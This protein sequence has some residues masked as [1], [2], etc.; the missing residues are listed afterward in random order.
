MTDAEMRQL[1]QIERQLVAE[2]PELR[3]L[4][5]DAAVAER[6]R[7]HRAWWW[8]GLATLVASLALLGCGLGLGIPGLAVSA[9][10]PPLAFGVVLLGG[11]AIHLRQPLWKRP[12]PPRPGSGRRR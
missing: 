11:L 3:R 10:C 7:R 6:R 5:D 2:S 1:A 8:G 9:L 4:F 12:K